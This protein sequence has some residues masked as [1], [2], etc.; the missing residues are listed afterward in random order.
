[1][2]MNGGDLSNAN[3]KK[4][5]P[6]YYY[7]LGLFLGGILTTLY[8]NIFKSR[9]GAFLQY[10]IVIGVAIG[11]PRLIWDKKQE[12]QAKEKIEAGTHTDNAL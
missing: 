8:E 11:V 10:A 1:M 3:K 4:G 6:W 9:P 7:I 12:R 5:P 2:S